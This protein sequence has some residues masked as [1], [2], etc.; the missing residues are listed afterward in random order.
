MSGLL[1][2]R[3]VAR[4]ALGVPAEFQV[5]G[6]VGRF[7]EEK[8]PLLAI[9]AL[10]GVADP[11]IVLCML[12]D[13][14]LLADARTRAR[15][16]GVGNR[17]FFPGSVPDASTLFLAFD[18]ILISSTTEGTP[19][20]ALEAAVAGIP[21]IATAVGG[22]PDLIGASGG[23]LVRSG[24]AGEI[25]QAMGDVLSNHAE[26]NRRTTHLSAA[27]RDADKDGDWVSQY[28]RLYEQVS[29]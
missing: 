10:A 9:D 29:R 22:I 5:V 15:V 18:A 13:G 19:M 26:A 2:T 6:W 11:R 17:V 16:A 12:G 21:V 4:A 20:V 1:A 23:W 25:G 3:A 24:D 28:L 14:P 27:L 8:A 7:S